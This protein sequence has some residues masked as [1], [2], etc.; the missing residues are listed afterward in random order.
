ML[1]MPG[2]TSSSKH[3]PE[4]H[5]GHP[6]QTDVLRHLR[7]NASKAELFSPQYLLPATQASSDPGNRATSP[8]RYSDQ[9][10]LSQH[11]GPYSQPPTFISPQVVIASSHPPGTAPLS[12]PK[13]TLLQRWALPFSPP[14][15]LLSP[16]P[17]SLSSPFPS[18][19][20]PP[21]RPV[22]LLLLNLQDNRG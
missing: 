10:G 8:S 21:G 19:S 16:L 18:S 5:P 15:P 7:V 6:N 11:S 14:L 2:D 1:P 22:S 17:P 4:Q 12:D 20:L 9:R 13:V 3:S